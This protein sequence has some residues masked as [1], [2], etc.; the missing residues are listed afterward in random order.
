MVFVSHQDISDPKDGV[1]ESIFNHRRFFPA[2]RL[3]LSLERERERV[4]TFWRSTR[5]KR[6]KKLGKRT[7][8]PNALFS[9]RADMFAALP[10]SS[11]FPPAVALHAV[12]F[13][14]FFVDA[15]NAFRDSIFSRKVSELV[16]VV[17]LSFL[18]AFKRAAEKEQ[19]EDARKDENLP[20]F[21]VFFARTS[22]GG[23][24]EEGGE[25]RP[26]SGR[27]IVVFL[28]QRSAKN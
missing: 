15:N 13:F 6:H 5:H 7:I 28:P 24:D 19:E 11:L 10:S 1:F 14:A 26:A 25:T 18:A 3:S 27:D 4:C 8:S 22:A 20:L 23:G 21:V 17:A 16:V 2:K 12:A 9:S